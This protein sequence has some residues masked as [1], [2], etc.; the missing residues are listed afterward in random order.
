MNGEKLVARA[1]T[2]AF[3]AGGTSQPFGLAG[4]VGK[5]GAPPDGTVQENLRRDH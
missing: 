3:S 1:E 4:P 5:L 2:V